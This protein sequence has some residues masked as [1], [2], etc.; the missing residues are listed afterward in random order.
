MLLNRAVQTSMVEAG[1]TAEMLAE[2]VG[3]DPKTAARWAREGRVPQTRHRARVAELLRRDIEDLWP[4][5]LRRKEPSW[6]RQWAEIEREALSL[7]TFQLAWIPGL[8][9]TEAYARAT[10]A[11][12][13]LT[14][15]EIGNLAAARVSRHAVLRRDR[16]PEFI[17]VIDEA[18]L[19][20]TRGDDRAMMAEQLGYLAECATLPSVQVF[21]VPR[22]AGMYCGLGGPFTV[23]E[24]PEGS[25]VG[26]VDSQAQAQI[27]YQAPDVA[28]L[29]RRW[30][31][32]RGEALSRQHSLTMIKE[33]ASSWT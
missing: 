18:V 33:A 27:V 4:D 25:R 9:Q 22:S 26:H 7:R 14:S 2:A 8:L 29:D 3:V 21:V 20:R 11:D 13:A 10:L 31:R 6:F 12:E 17:A 23:A 28:T 24:M 16:P 5:A 15:V 1:L 19:H 30:E 32:I